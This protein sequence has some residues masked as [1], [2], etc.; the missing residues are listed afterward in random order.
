MN[1]LVM[2]TGGIGGYYG[3]L[4]AKAGQTVTFIA[5]GPHLRAIRAEGLQVRSGYGDIIVK[6]AMATDELAGLRSPDLILFCT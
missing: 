2:G 4:L 6:P 3:A 5:R 1:I